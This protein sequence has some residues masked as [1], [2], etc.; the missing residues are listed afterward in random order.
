MQLAQ[1][2]KSTRCPMCNQLVTD[3]HKRK[4][5][6]DVTAKLGK[7]LTEADIVK[8]RGAQADAARDLV[9]AQ[10]AERVCTD[11]VNAVL[12]AIES[13]KKDIVRDRA[14]LKLIQA[15]L[16]PHS[17]QVKS[18]Q[19]RRANIEHET[20]QAQAA[21][22]ALT[23]TRAATHV[24]T[25]AFKDMKLMLLD[26]VVS[27]LSILST[28]YAGELGIDVSMTFAVERETKSGSIVK[29]ITCSL[30]TASKFETLSGGEGQR[31]R[32]AASLALSHALLGHAGIETDQMMLDEPSAHLSPQGLRELTSFLTAHARSSSRTLFLT[33]Q[34]P[35]SDVSGQMT[36]VRTAEETHLEAR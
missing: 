10:T 23:K 2:L 33:D 35:L 1:M 34:R 13:V 8:A 19:A 12:A 9:K 6:R 31:L 4:H 28:S 27:T 36:L 25:Q 15:Q 30:D 16:N 24:W 21:H 3:E 29:G 17:D 22:D 26:D 18:L 20:A 11:E 5:K 32:I 14:N 7:G